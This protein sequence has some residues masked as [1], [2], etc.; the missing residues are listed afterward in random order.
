MPSGKVH[1]AAEMALLSV[2]SA[3]GVGMVLR[4]GLHAVPLATFLGSFLFSSLLLS[5]DLDLA[6]SDAARRWGIARVLWIPYAKVFRH[7][8]T[9]HRP[10]L[11]PLTRI[12]YL[13]ILAVAAAALLQWAIGGDLAVVWP[14]WPV[15]GAAAL[16]LYLPNLV[17]ILLDRVAP[18]RR[19]R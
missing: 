3:V 4:S 12:A 16:G 13:T 9:S 7:R 2:L 1:L 15:A 18:T 19:R 6:R 17:H 5:P 10:L 8:R 14:G 11:G